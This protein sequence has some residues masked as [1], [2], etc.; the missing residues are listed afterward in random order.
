[1]IVHQLSPDNPA[2]LDPV[3]IAAQPTIHD[4]ARVLLVM[5][6]AATKI[7]LVVRPMPLVETRALLHLPSGKLLNLQSVPSLKFWK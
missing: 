6:E 7:G 1:M 4:V 5:Y 3:D 2:S